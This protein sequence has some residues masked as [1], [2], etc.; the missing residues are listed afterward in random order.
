MVADKRA[1]IVTLPYLYTYKR[2]G[3]M[4]AD[5]VE[6]TRT[7][8]EGDVNSVMRIRVEK[9][10]EDTATVDGADGVKMHDL[11]MTEEELLYV[12]LDELAEGAA[13]RLQHWGQRAQVNI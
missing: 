4:E 1:G 10:A 3:E 2:H 8:E 9:Q 5:D 13:R 11:D 6:Y 7:E 12:K